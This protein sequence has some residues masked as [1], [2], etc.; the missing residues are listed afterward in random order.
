[1]HPGLAGPP[2]TDGVL[3]KRVGSMMFRISMAGLAIALVA[4]PALADLPLP[5]DP[6]SAFGFSSASFYDGITHYLPFDPAHPGPPVPDTTYKY[7]DFKFGSGTAHAGYFDQQQQAFSNYATATIGFSPL[8]MIDVSATNPDTSPGAYAYAHGEIHYDYKVDIA[9]N[10]Q[11]FMPDTGYASVV[12]I[13]GITDIATL[14]PV[15]NVRIAASANGN[16]VQDLSLLQTSFGD[17]SNGGSYAHQGSFSFGGAAQY[18]GSEIIGGVT[19]AVLIGSLVM[20]ADIRGVTHGTTFLD[21]NGVL[22]T[23]SVNDYL[24]L[25]GRAFIDPVISINPAFLQLHGLSGGFVTLSNGVS[26]AATA[27]PEPASWAMLITGFGLAGAAL[28]RRRL[29][30]A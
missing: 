4:S 3:I 29:V 7:Y 10:G 14:G 22:Q 25:G 23:V 8:A 5:T 20:Q 9:A 19:Y 1:M 24:G 13:A 21:P 6:N 27:V 30:S 11:T 2:G 17:G 16:Q 28:R 26:N 15:S 12:T 18:R